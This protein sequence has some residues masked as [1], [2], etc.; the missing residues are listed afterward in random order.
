MT[1]YPYDLLSTEKWNDL[2]HIITLL[3]CSLCAGIGRGI[4]IRL[5]ELGAAVI[6][7]SRTKEDLD[8]LKIE[9]SI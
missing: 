4:A 1:I 2:I 7:V 3:K 9:V 5:A 8:S 6:A